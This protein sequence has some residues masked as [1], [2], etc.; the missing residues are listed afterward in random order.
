LG[1]LLAS[2]I[3][4]GFL[5][6][7]IEPQ[8]WYVVTLGAFLIPVIASLVFGWCLGVQLPTGVLGF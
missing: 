2:V 8:K 3:L 7:A 6:R 4:M 5:L 1:F